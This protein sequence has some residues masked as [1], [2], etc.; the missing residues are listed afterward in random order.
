M[1]YLFLGLLLLAFGG[2]SQKSEPQPLDDSNTS[3]LVE[4]DAN[5]SL[6]IL[7]L[8][9]FPQ[10]SSAYVDNINDTKH[11]L[12]IQKQYEAHYFAPWGY[13]KAPETLEHIMWPY[14]S[15]KPD[16][17]FG[18]NLQPLEQAWF[19]KMLKNANFSHYDSV[20]K[21]AIATDYISLR[22]FPTHKPLFKN[23]NEAGEGFPF[24]YLQNSGVHANE[25]LYIS[26][27][28]QDKA[29]VYVF[30]AY[31]TGWVDVKKIAYVSKN[32]IKKYQEAKM[33]HV[34]IDDFPIID[35][36]GHFVFN[37]RVGMRL[38][39]IKIDKD[40]YT[41]L[42]ITKGAYFNPTYTVVKV[43]RRVG[44]HTL[45]T[46]SRENLETMTNAMMENNYGWG[47]L[48][49]ERDCSS[50]LKDLF[51]PF[52]IW[53]PRNSAQQARVGKKIDLSKYDNSK[54]IEV[55]K[56][57]GIP[58]ETLI[59]RKGH[60]LLYLGVYEDDVMVM[61]TV[62]GIKTND[63]NKS[64]RV[65]IGKTVISTLNLGAHQEHFDVENSLINKVSSMNILTR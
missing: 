27:F 48:Y 10:D 33:L 37:S 58:F 9:H 8:Q 52:G 18:E 17:A 60:I 51:A 13:K 35:T 26:H 31:A 64:G 63:G 21:Y 28:S 40:Y 42:T 23:P 19:D 55:I 39:L 12:E 62:W 49:G 32:V 45:L 1:R 22:N 30:S 46:L 11:L 20:K 2:C 59:Y 65:V 43:P 16:D 56:K 61:H 44:S 47:G 53:L 41:A 7:D 29:W 24:D 3:P 5:E 14:T 38:P 54:K 25:P 6:P 57:E 15:Y 36:K 4:L 34:M 50:T